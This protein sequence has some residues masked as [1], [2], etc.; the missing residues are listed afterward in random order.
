MAHL[1]VA[2]N[3]SFYRELLTDAMQSAGHQV[4]TCAD[5]SQALEAVMEGRF[6][7]IV[8][9]LVMPRMGGARAC[10]QIKKNPAS[11]NIPVVI[12][13][14]LRQEE[15]DDAEDI[16]AD[17]FVAKMQATEMIQHLTAVLDGL[18]SG[19][20]VAR[21]RGFDAMHRREVVSELLE[22]RR[23]REQ[24]LG[25]LREGF[26]R[27]SG[28]GRVIEANPAA[29][30][31]LGED[32]TQM[33]NRQAADILGWSRADLDALFA[34]DRQMTSRRVT[35]GGGQFD[36]RG[37]GGG[38]DD[39]RFLFLSSVEGALVRDGAAVADDASSPV[40]PGTSLGEI[41]A[42]VA[43]ELKNPLTGILG[44]SELLLQF[45][46]D[47]RLRDRLVKIDREA[48]RCRRLVDS[49]LCFAGKRQTYRR[50]HD[51]NGV[52]TRMLARET[53]AAGDAGVEVTADLDPKLS[54]V[55]VDGA[56]IEQVLQNLLV[57][58]YR[59]LSSRPAGDRQVTVRTRAVEDRVVLEV[60]DNGP[61]VPVGSRERIFEPFFTTHRPEGAAGLGLAASYGIVEENGGR[62]EALDGMP[63]AIF[64][65]E[66]P[67]A[68]GEQGSVRR[69]SGS[70][71]ALIVE[72][73]Q[74][75]VDL[76]DD[77]LTDAGYRVEC[78][79][80]GAQALE[81]ASVVEFDAVLIDVKMADLDGRHLVDTIRHHRTHPECR[82]V[83]ITDDPESAPL[84]ELAEQ[85][86]AVVLCKPFQVEDVVKACQVV[87][88]GDPQPPSPPVA[89]A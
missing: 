69:V 64:R 9:D 41:V 47:D 11:R 53:L 66:L 58:A 3:S 30:G 74:V 71:T 63:G 88:D 29:I 6:D 10:R 86:S 89:P 56:Q 12:L 25:S 55:N 35:I 23:S 48:R 20:P 57:N 60:Q 2:D 61:G 1:L 38:R 21:N 42:G 36:V 16:G 24:L 45:A 5:G 15:I 68:S 59:A 70:P 31:M 27:L 33:V 83:F 39:D 7:A 26:L 80:N 37:H 44:Y 79:R 19:R 51:L 87:A 13:S 28:T 54:L 17:A 67:P 4:T 18:L 43:H 50:A 65:V 81:R 40:W 82:V 84:G 46:T 49:L 62:I 73:E 52:V 14:G 72:H 77:I 32:E 22:E 78:A 85:T 8:L 76:L 34:P 75:V